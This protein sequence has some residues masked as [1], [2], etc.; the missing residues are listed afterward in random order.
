MS[1]KVEIMMT[2]Q[3]HALRKEL[4]L[5]GVKIFGETPSGF[6]VEDTTRLD[7][8]T[9][10]YKHTESVHLDFQ[11]L[12]YDLHRNPPSPCDSDIDDHN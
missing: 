9:C 1:Q 4:R 5:L 3:R 8:L 11:M 12:L 6:E 2:T 10:G 7:Q